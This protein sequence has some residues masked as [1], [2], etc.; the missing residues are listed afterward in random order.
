MTI[1]YLPFLPMIPFSRQQLKNLANASSLERGEDY[2]Y[3]GAVQ[4]VTRLGNTFE[5]EVEGSEQYRVKLEVTLTGLFF[6]CSCPYDFGGICKH[7]VAMGLAILEGKFEELTQTANSDHTNFET[8]YDQTTTD[9]K[10]AFLRQ[11]LLK[12][13]VLRNQF[14]QFNK[15]YDSTP[16]DSTQNQSHFDLIRERVAEGLSALRFDDGMFTNRHDLYDSEGDELYEVAQEM[17]EKILDSHATQALQLVKQGKLAESC[18]LLQAVYE[19]IQMADDPKADDFCLF[20][21]TDYV[22]YMLDEVFTKV[23]KNNVD[24]IEKGV[25]P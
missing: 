14:I 19:G 3:E 17:I 1:D 7:S 25:F 20:D 5:G 21:S 2:Y 6:R 10:L 15:S 23:L 24:Q 13:D 18:W 12:D 11:L 8:F 16:A 22:Q 9:H 4:N